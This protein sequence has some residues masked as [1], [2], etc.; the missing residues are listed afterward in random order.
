MK[1][2]EVDIL[3]FGAHPDD[4]EIGVGGVL[5]KHSQAGFVTAICNLTEAELS[6]N[7]TVET[8]RKEASRAAEILG[9]K[10]LIN[11]KLPDRSIRNVPH[12]VERLTQ[13]IRRYRPKVVLA[14]YFEDRHPDHVTCSQMVDEAVFDAAIRKQR[15]SGGEA[16]H[17]VKHVFYYFIND[18]KPADLI[19]DISD[20]YEQK[21]KAILAYETQFKRE[22]GEV[23][24]P[25][26]GSTYLSMM[27]GR[28]QLWGNQIQ[29]VYGEGLKTRKPLTSSFLV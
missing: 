20:V 1:H 28:D 7:G 5:A 26:N 8:R 16:A 24:T 18:I 15:T 19:I 4:V 3:A 9:V 17:R 10:E 21:T 22:A 13:M 14:P 29:A 23:E 27:R 11:L 6:S 12:Q 2:T 25:L